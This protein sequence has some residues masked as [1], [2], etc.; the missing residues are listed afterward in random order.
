M[1]GSINCN[2]RLS[3]W[4]NFPSMPDSKNGPIRLTHTTAEEVAHTLMK[5]W[6]AGVN[7]K[8]SLHRLQHK[9]KFFCR[10]QERLKLDF[11]IDLESRSQQIIWLRL[12][13]Q[14]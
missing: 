6:M 13:L 8:C 4:Y 11:Q 1:S 7:S 12:M 9:K 3:T 10:R 2:R 14:I 5:P